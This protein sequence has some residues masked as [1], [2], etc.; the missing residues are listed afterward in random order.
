MYTKFDDAINPRIILANTYHL[1]VQPSTEIVD[2]MG[3]IHEF[4]DISCNLLTDSGGFQMVSLLELAHIT[5]EGVNFRSH[6]DGKEVVLT[7]EM[8][9]GHQNRIG[10]DIIMQLDDVVR[11]FVCLFLS[12]FV[13]IYVL[14]TH[15]FVG[16]Q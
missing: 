8:S 6:V 11:L 16:Y 13:F 4:M 3:G 2:T 14:R 1:A 12:F 9:I 15:V 10:G 7:P 5:E